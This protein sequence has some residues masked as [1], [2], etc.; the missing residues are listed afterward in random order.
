MR[1]NLH[2][3]LYIIANNI[4]SAILLELTNFI[5]VKKK[6]GPIGRP[7]FIYLICF[8]DLIYSNATNC[9]PLLIILVII[10][11]EA[12]SI[13]DYEYVHRADFYLCFLIVCLLGNLIK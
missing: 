13:S 10:S 8:I 5:N 4:I 7:H 1:A 6:M 2:G 12:G 11:G 3:Y 9:F